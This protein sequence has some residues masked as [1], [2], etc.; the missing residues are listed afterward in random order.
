MARTFCSHKFAVWFLVPF[1]LLTIGATAVIAG[2]DWI[3][4]KSTRDGITLFT[5][6][7][8][9][10]TVREIRAKMVINA[11]PEAV[12]EAACAPETYKETTQKY[13]ESNH[14]F[15]VKNP[16]V[17]FNY[18]LVDFPVIAKR[19][20][21]LRYEKIMNPEKGIYQLNWRVSTRFGPPP[22]QGVVRV[23]NVRGLVDIKP[24][25]GGK[26]SLMRYTLLADPGGDIPTWI[27]N[28]AN[29]VSLPNILRE[30]KDASLKRQSVTKE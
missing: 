11:S 3:H 18:Q 27:I 20:Y 25:D 2:N 22:Q 6:T 23:S 30:I 8:P 7:T 1:I 12:L 16:N 4:E 14:Y 21:C 13:V 5:R 26:K 24:Q 10:T 17:W 9:G 15:K 29:R 28:L 19:D